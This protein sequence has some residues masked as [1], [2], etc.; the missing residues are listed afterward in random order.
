MEKGNIERFFKYIKPLVDKII[1]Y[2]DCSTD[3]SYEYSLN[4]A[5]K[6]IRGGNNNFSE[7]VK[8]KSLLLSAALEEKADF[9][10]CIDADELLSCT[11]DQLIALCEECAKNKYDGVSM[12]EINLWR[13]STWKRTDSLYDEGWFTKIWKVKKDL[14][15]KNKPGLHQSLAPNGIDEVLKT[16]KVSIIHYGFYDEKNIAYKYLTYK[17][18]GQRGYVMLDRIIS[19]DRLET[20][21]VDKEYIP[22]ELYINDEKKPNKLALADSIHYIYNYREK[23]TRPK[24]SIACLIYKSVDWLKFVYEQVLKYTDLSDKE[25]YFVAN[26]AN[27]E[28][29]KYLTEN[30]LP[31]YIFNNTEEHKKEWYINNVY[32]AWN[33]AAE[34]AKGDFIIFINSDMAFSNNWSENLIDKYDGKNC[35]ASRLVESGKLTPGKYGI[36]KN[37]GTEIDNYKEQDFQLYQNKIKRDAINEGGLFMPLLI[38]KKDFIGVGGYPEGNAKIGSNIH[39]PKIARL[40]EPQISGDKILMDKLALRGIKHKTSFQSVVYHFQCGEMDSKNENKKED[41]TSIAVINDL[42]GGIMGEK[43][44]WNFILENILGSYPLDFKALHSRQKKFKKDCQNILKEKNTKIIIQNASFIEKISDEIYTIAFL[45]DDLRAMGKKSIQQEINLKNSDKIVTNSINTAASYSEYDCEII[46]VGVDSNL[47]Y[48][49]KNKEYLKEKNLL[50]TNKK[51]GIFVGDFSEVKG[52]S[53]IKKIIECHKE[54]FWILVT[55]KQ[56]KYERNDVIV[57][58]QINQLLLSE[59]LNCADFFILGSPI[60]TQCLAAIEAGLCNIPIVMHKTGI[61]GDISEDELNK[62]GYFGDDLEIGIK[63]ISEKIFYPRETLIKYGV[64]VEASMD[65]WKRLLQKV[66]LEIDSKK[67]DTK[68]VESDKKINNKIIFI[69]HDII[70]NRII[71][72]NVSIYTKRLIIIILKKLG[73]FEITKKVYKLIRHAQ[74]K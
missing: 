16:E 34:Q 45:Q 36:K 72:E 21:K 50:K 70:I 32:R 63:E 57:F 6:V 44:F 55:K 25:F 29:I 10:V 46:P 56:E 38:K 66:S 8:H 20:E 14:S 12:K 5:D 31:H 49:Q 67:F 54:I 47:F 51:I 23:I 65:K 64:T 37:F 69:I 26:D 53:E 71:A 11:K 30:H 22:N 7:E 61:F 18:H 40:G 62:I 74:S 73:L 41:S 24:Y 27:D 48:P 60:E 58:N 3:G 33:Y 19:E 9:I 68:K 35:I 28:V 2:D 1:I 15:Y 17:K 42:T 13:S 52:W 43:V 4:N 59:L 39:S